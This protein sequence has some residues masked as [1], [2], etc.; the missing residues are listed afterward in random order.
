MSKWKP[1]VWGSTATLHFWDSP[2]GSAHGAHLPTD[3]EGDEPEQICHGRV[4]PAGL[5][6]FDAHVPAML[7]ASPREFA[8]L[9]QR[10]YRGEKWW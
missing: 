5:R 8:D 1:K 2:K 9:R 4:S 3:G 10:Q 7:G 6:L